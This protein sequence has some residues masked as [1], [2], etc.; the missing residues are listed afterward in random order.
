M[1]RIHDTHFSKQ[2]LQK[3]DQGLEIHL[4]SRFCSNLDGRIKQWLGS[5]TSAFIRET[6]FSPFRVAVKY[7][8]DAISFNSFSVAFNV[9]FFC[10]VPNFKTL[11]PVISFHGSIKFSWSAISVVHLE[12]P[13]SQIS[14]NVIVPH[15]IFQKA[16]YKNKW[17]QN[18]HYQDICASTRV[19]KYS[20]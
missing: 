16:F 4:R 17:K 2:N 10:S 3:H 13:P 6:D 15:H 14:Y 11:F 5:K 1:W 20:W 9:V 18:N 7:T 19:L 8:V 12:T